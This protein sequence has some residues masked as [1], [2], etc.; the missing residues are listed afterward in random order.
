MRLLLCSIELSASVNQLL[1]HCL[2][3][4]VGIQLHLGVLEL[5]QLELIITLCQEFLRCG[6]RCSLFQQLLLFRV[7]FTGCFF[8][9]ALKVLQLWRRGRLKR[10]AFHLQLLTFFD[11]CSQLLFQVCDDALGL[12]NQFSLLL[13]LKLGRHK[14]ATYLLY[15]TV[16]ACAEL[17]LLRDHSDKFCS[18]SSK[19][20]LGET[21]S[22]NLLLL[23]GIASPS[24]Q[25]FHLFNLF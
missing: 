9:Q 22:L 7:Q 1:P 21:R 8:A 18:H 24:C 15:F 10:M 13:H 25:L 12:R 19:V 5:D 17:I 16:R 23:F 3:T 2:H 6:S 20:V 14:S 4:L 11:T